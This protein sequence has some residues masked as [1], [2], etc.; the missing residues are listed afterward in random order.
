MISIWKDHYLIRSFDCGV[1]KQAKLHALINY[2]QESAHYHAIHLGFGYDELEGMKQFWALSRLQIRILGWPFWGDE[3]TIET[4]PKSTINPFAYRDFEVFDKSGNKILIGSTGWLMLDSETR[5]PIRDLSS[6]RTRIQ[7]PEGKFAI[8]ELPP[9]LNA[10]K[11]GTA[12]YSIIAGKADLDMNGHVNNTVYIEWI[13]NSLPIDFYNKFEIKELSINYLAEILA[14]N[15]I[16]IYA[17]NENTEW[18]LE[19]MREP[20]SVSV[21]RAKISFS[22]KV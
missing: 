4:W 10:V 11:N 1:N 17:V 20:E 22:P 7:Y 14:G 12:I 21:F 8:E 13:I 18:I 6:L 2:F 19:A 5:R 3:I 9:K 15:K 16:A